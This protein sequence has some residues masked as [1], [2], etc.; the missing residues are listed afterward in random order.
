MSINITK[1]GTQMITIP[2][3]L[4]DILQLTTDIENT[5]DI[6][7]KEIYKDFIKLKLKYV[8]GLIRGL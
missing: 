3:L 5:D 4:K 6:R 7:D 1:G 8:E 2:E